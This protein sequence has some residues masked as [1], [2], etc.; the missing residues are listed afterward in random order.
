MLL[1]LLLA[2]SACGDGGSPG[3]APTVAP[4][5]TA[6]TGSRPSAPAPTGTASGA[7]SRSG[8]PAPPSRTAAPAPPATRPAAARFPAR[9]AGRD[10]ER[11][12]TGRRVIALTFAA[13][14]DAGA[15]P[16][17]LA[18]LAHERV[19]ATFFLTGRF[20]TAFP[21]SARRIAAAGHRLG[22]HSVSHPHFPRLTG[23]QIRAEVLGAAAT[24]R[25]GTG[26][27]PAPLFRFPYGD[28]DPRTIATVNGLGYLPVRWTV[29]SLGWQGTQ[30]GT[31]DAS[32]VTRRVLA[33]AD[34][35][36]IVLMHAGSHPT[37]RSTLDAAA[38]PA[39]IAGLRRDGYRF[40]TLDA[41]LT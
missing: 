6:P 31:R 25:A 29:D 32:F 21:E 1:G 13:G 15:V 4:S 2:A 19:P 39:I 28:R 3:P 12:P 17:L 20:V 11:I 23:A 26:V 40:V 34:P 5:P 18:T 9:L 36:G 22:D 38:L 10:V 41:L 7:P 14:S 35:G 30:G 37:D 24:I 8:V 16:A 27:D 33:A